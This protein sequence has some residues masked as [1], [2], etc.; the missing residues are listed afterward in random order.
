MV[1][2]RLSDCEKSHF[3]IMSTVT[4]I[5][6]DLLDIS[7]LVVTMIADPL[8]ARDV[9]LYLFLP[10]MSAVKLIGKIGK[11]SGHVTVVGEFL[12][13][14]NLILVRFIAVVKSYPTWDCGGQRT[15]DE[16]SDNL[17]T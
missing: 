11:T 10:I 1:Y 7:V 12:A 8:T 9:I 13:E 3:A 14:M 4:T 6:S 5:I 2:V 16:Y 17:L 15:V